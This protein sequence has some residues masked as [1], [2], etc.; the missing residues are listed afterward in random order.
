MCVVTRD[1]MHRHSVA[2]HGTMGF[3]LRDA[4]EEGGA[5]VVA[6]LHAPRSVTLFFSL[7]IWFW[8][9]Y[10][11]MARFAVGHNVLMSMALL[12]VYF[13]KV[14]NIDALV[15]LSSPDLACVLFT[16]VLSGGS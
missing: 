14:G 5:T 4:L 12:V 1:F 11:K 8:N 3:Y 2:L 15:C 16:F 6:C 13:L 7:D 10:D 9:E